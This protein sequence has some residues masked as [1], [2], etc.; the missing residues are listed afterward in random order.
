MNKT[1]AANYEDTQAEEKCNL[2]TQICLEDNFR[3]ILV[4]FG[5]SKSIPRFGKK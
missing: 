4:F 3:N 2:R 1:F 5:A